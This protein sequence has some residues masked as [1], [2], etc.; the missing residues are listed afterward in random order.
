MDD[1]EQ[2]PPQATPEQMRAIARRLI[3]PPAIVTA[4]V[5]AAMIWG[6][7]YWKKG[8]GSKEAASSACAA[9]TALAAQ[10]APLA[11]G[12]IAGLAIDS[13]PQ[14]MPA[15]S[16]SSDKGPVDLASFK[17]R[18]VLLNLWATWCVPCRE[19]MPSLDRLQGLVGGDTFTVA[20]VNIDTARRDRPKK[21]LKR[22]GVKNLTFYANP[23]GDVLS[24]L[25]A[26]GKV[27]G[28]PTSFLVGPDGCRVGVI[29]GPAKWD[30]AD[31]LALIKAA[32]QKSAAE[33]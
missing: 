21:F 19:E 10:L 12:G 23:D 26:T 24:T 11:K 20:A 18:T 28:L 15:L 32:A 6:V 8:G 31:A 14:P 9:S 2:T 5:V 7:L 17:G 4:V 22:I 16:F 29:A 30:G 1:E 25:K 13:R 33:K 3:L 27:V